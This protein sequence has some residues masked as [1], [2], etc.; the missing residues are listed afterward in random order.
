MTCRKAN[1]TRLFIQWAVENGIVF[2]VSENWF[3]PERPVTRQEMAAIMH[4][5]MTFLGLDLADGGTAFEDEAQ[6][7]GVGAGRRNFHAR[8]RHPEW[9][10]RATCFD[11]DANSTRRRGCD[12][13]A[14]GLLN[15]L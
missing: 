9:Q 10:G 4:R 14:G 11:P 6:I 13:C 5:F 2:G 1:I 12:G 3:E 15:I 8:H 7:A